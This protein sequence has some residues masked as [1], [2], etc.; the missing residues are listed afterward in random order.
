MVRLY[1]TVRYNVK[2]CIIW[3][4]IYL[5]KTLQYSRS[6][7]P[8]NAQM[9]VYCTAVRYMEFYSLVT[10]EYCLNIAV[11][12]SARLNIAWLSHD[13]QCTFKYRTISVRCTMHIWIFHACCTLYDICLN[14]VQPLYVERQMLHIVQLLHTLFEFCTTDITRKSAI[15]D[16]CQR[17]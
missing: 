8:H 13:V 11:H 9:V 12:C 2:Y 3:K 4:I 10:F 14:T 7:V 6:S 5:N 17:H 16:I 15:T 1:S